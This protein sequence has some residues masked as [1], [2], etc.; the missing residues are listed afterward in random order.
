MSYKLEWLDR[1]FMYSSYGRASAMKKFGW[2]DGRREQL[3]NIKQRSGMRKFFKD[4]N[5]SRAE[6]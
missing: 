6:L 3:R 5:G 1:C 4:Y 2:A